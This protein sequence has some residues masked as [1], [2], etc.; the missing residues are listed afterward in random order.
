MLWLWSRPAATAPIRPLPWEAPNA[1][2]TA[3]EKTKGKERKGKERKGKER[4]GKERKGKERKGKEKK[5][6]AL[7]N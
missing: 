6:Q 4:K 7:L 1:T 2:G 3:L 5:I